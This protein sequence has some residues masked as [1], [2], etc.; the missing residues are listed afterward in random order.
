[1]PRWQRWKV[2][3]G[4]N[5]ESALEHFGV[6]YTAVNTDRENIPVDGGVVIVANHPLGALDAL[7]LLD[8]VGKVRRDARILANDVLMQLAPLN[9]L[10]LLAKPLAALLLGRVS[11]RRFRPARWSARASRSIKWPRPCVAMSTSW[12][13]V[14]LT[15]S[16]PPRRLH[17]PSRR[18]RCAEL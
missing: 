7:C 10:L 1:M 11:A 6:S 14:V 8:L 9:S 17:I 15:C 13:S 5:F 4:S 18:L 12:P 2:C 3:P 16:P